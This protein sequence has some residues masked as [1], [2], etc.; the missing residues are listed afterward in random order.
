MQNSPHIVLFVLLVT[1]L[2]SLGWKTAKFILFWVEFC[3]FHLIPTFSPPL[4]TNNFYCV[5]IHG[6]RLKID[7]TE[8][9][10]TSLYVIIGMN[11][12][13]TGVI[14]SHVLE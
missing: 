4:V 7:L 3:E 1:E 2:S 10:N 8:T 14:I 11:E 5:E 6:Y 12:N 9:I 13:T